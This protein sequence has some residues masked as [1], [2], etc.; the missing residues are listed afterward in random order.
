MRILGSLTLFFLLTVSG[1]GEVVFAK[2][3]NWDRRVVARHLAGHSIF[4]GGMKVDELSISFPHRS[5]GV[6][7]KKLAA[8]ELV[9]ATRVSTLRNI[10]LHGTN[11]VAETELAISKNPFIN[12]RV[13]SLRVGP[14]ARSFVDALRKAERLPEVQE[15][16]FELRLLSSPPHFQALWL[17][18]QSEDMFIPIS[19][20]HPLT[21]ADL[22]YGEKEIVHALANGTKLSKI[23]SGSSAVYPSIVGSWGNQKEFFQ[24]GNF[25]IVRWSTA[26]GH[27]LQKRIRGGK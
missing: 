15:K 13:Q 17:H 2:M 4:L 19:R 22:V 6:E 3:S 16:D 24:G 7:L 20:F 26:E 12:G 11:V 25:E 21:F 23:L 27:L 8:G 1:Q 10:I 14:L 18:R 9:S 5:Y